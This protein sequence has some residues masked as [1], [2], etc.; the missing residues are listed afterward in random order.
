[1]TWQDRACAET[2]ADVEKLLCS[3]ARD[4]QHRSGAD[5][6]DLISEVKITFMKAYYGGY[7]EASR[8]TSWVG[9]KATRDLQ[10]RARDI[11]R[12][13]ARFPMCHLDFTIDDADDVRTG[14]PTWDSISRPEP[15]TF[16]ETVFDSLSDDGRH[17]AGL[18][19]RPPLPVIL[20]AEQRHGRDN[21]YSLRLAIKEYL[22]DL[23]WTMARI[24]EAF[25]EVASVL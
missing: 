24:G 14:M 15:P 9:F 23:G 16:D 1:M 21:G 17:V 25:Q 3:I 7:N 18:A 12:Y 6:D 22:G 2:W 13:N 8:F 5:L 11:A 10:S 4:F 20:T 19:L